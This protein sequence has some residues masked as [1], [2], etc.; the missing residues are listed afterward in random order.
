MVIS[1]ALIEIFSHE[2]LRQAL[3][4]RG[5]TALFKLHLPA[6][7]YSEDIDLVQV[8]AEP[9]GPIMDALREVL[10]P[11]LGEPKRKQNNALVTL[12]YRF[13]SEDGQPL[14]L[15]VEINTREHFAVEGF[16]ATPFEVNS[17]WYK[18]SCSILSYDLNELLGTKLRALYQRKKGRDLFDLAIA[19]DDEAADPEKIVAAFYAYMA[20][21][22]Y[23]V[24]RK[25]F[26]ENVAA[27]LKDK[28]FASDIG[29]LLASGYEW[30][31]I[32]MSEKV[33]DS[34]MSRLS[35]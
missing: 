17:R 16:Q 5:G 8:N 11:W 14:R 21:G 18:G 34:L 24:T 30:D 7:R 31:L 6:A 12:A 13:Q 20:H 9:A 32:A 22:G 2:T 27:K 19:L 33:N 10:D 1:R 3:A 29:P 28:N 35:E 25:Q 15:K 23:K 26:Q 4:F